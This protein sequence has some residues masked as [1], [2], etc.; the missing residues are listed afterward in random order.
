MWGTWDFSFSG[1]KTAVVNEVRKNSSLKVK[2]ICAAFQRA[3]VET[4][5]KKTLAARNSTG[6]QE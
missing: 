3:V 6:F 2:D 1:I 4:I 5:V